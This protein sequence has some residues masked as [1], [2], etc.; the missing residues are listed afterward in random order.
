[1]T[2]KIILQKLQFLL[3]QLSS[4]PLV[5]GLQISDYALQ[6]V[7][8]TGELRTASVKMPPGVV[9]EGRL[10][11]GAQF[12][13]YL[14]QLHQIVKP[15]KEKE[16]I[17]VTVTLPPNVVYTQSFT[18][19]N[20]GVEKLEESAALNIQ[21]IS[22]MSPDAAYISWQVIR[23]TPDQY[24]LL[25]AF[26]EKK[27]VDEFQKFLEESYFSSV[28]F[29]FP[30]LSL[31]RLIALAGNT[32]ESPSLL[33]QIS[34]D[35]LNLSI[36]K[37]KGLYFDY[38]RSWRSVQGESRQI[39]RERFEEVVA[40]EIQKVINFTLSKFKESPKKLFMIAPGFETEIQSFVQLKFGISVAVLQVTTWNISSQWYAAVGAALRE[41][42]SRKRDILINVSS[43]RSGQYFYEEQGLKFLHLWRIIIAGVLGVFLLLFGGSAY[44][45]ANELKVTKQNLSIFSA[46]I[47]AGEL[48]SL[49]GNVTS[50]NA[51]VKSAHL[52]K[53]ASEP[54]TLFFSRI[55]T[56]ADANKVVIDSIDTTSLKKEITLNAHV[57]DNNAI[58][59]FK[60]AISVEKDF[61]DVDL[62]VSRIVTREDG[63]AGF[64]L[65]FLF[66]GA[67]LK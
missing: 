10:I 61:T 23:E 3:K 53:D 18:V 32:D 48:Q 33:L 40:E 66:A 22:P 59:T 19:P 16:P 8:L 7:A 43:G 5:G 41:S 37:S 38:F 9:R 6:Y 55:K 65:T 11:D 63:S 24:E 64:Q 36:L 25:G 51:L 52:V 14:K 28:A 47:P 1:M 35:G 2:I 27:Y 4:E 62:L 17:P 44:V 26:A 13:L 20:V 42:E 39:T 58:I 21:M 15:E 45:L 54:W 50:F 31:S 34:S 12:L 29:E 67:A 49:E 60:N 56:I 57:A 46:R 30:S